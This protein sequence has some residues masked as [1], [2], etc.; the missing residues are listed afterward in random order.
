MSLDDFVDVQERHVRDMTGLLMSKS[1]EKAGSLDPTTVS[2]RELV[3]LMTSDHISFDELKV[4]AAKHNGVTA[5]IGA[6]A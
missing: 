2:V 4:A 5:K 3:E 6:E 1:N